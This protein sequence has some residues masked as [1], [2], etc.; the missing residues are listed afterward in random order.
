VNREDRFV[1]K[2]RGLLPSS[3]GL[4]VGP[5]DDA[6]ILDLRPGP[7]AATTDLLVEGVDFFPGE[8]PERLGRRAVAVNLSD[9]GAVGAA[10]EFFLLS[11]AFPPQ[12]GEEFPLAVAR[13]AMARADPFGARLAGG[14]LSGAPGIVVSVA[15]WGRLVGSPLLRSGARPGDE[16]FVSGHLGQAAAGLTL[17]GRLAAFAA[18]GSSPTPRFPE[19][20]PGHQ[21]QLLD[22]F[23]DPSPPVALGLALA[24]ERLAHAAIDVSDGLGVDAGR[25]ARASGVRIVIE[26]DRL[27][28]SA[29][30]LSFG[31]MEE[32]DPIELMLAGGDD[33]ELLFAVP[34]D[35]GPRLRIQAERLGVRVTRI[36]RIEAGE[37]AVMRA[38][39]S[40]RDISGLGHDHFEAGR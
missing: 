12:R 19:L 35:A 27:P 38:G 40:E 4:R 39:G 11:I 34:P 31:A 24:E 21:R 28:V 26:G 29:A 13:G 23:R 30:L 25:L 33:Y 6:A 14:D 7:I 37:G 1:E 8:D 17:A 10:P 15:L 5:G 36:G 16:L 3:E 20:A 32:C 9:L 2:L 22:A 18:Q